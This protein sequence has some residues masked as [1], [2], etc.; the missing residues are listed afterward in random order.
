MENINKETLIENAKTI[1]ED[2]YPVKVLNKRQAAQ[3]IGVSFSKL[4]NM[5]KLSQKNINSGCPDFI[6][7]ED[8]HPHAIYY[9]IEDLDMWINEN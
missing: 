6:T 3:Y 7:N 9:A 8:P 5:R 2:S 4:K 1:H